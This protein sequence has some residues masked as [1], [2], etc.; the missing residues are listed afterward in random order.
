MRRY[1]TL[2][3]G[4]RVTLAAY[5]AAWRTCTAAAPGTVFSRG[6]CGYGS[7]TREQVLG[8]FR[9][10]VHDR[11]NR[12]DSRY[13]RGRKWD[14]D[15]WWS[16]MRCARAVNTPRLVVHSVPLDFAARLRHR[17]WAGEEW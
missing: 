3:D 1:V 6:L 5:A 15:W 9:D 10:G 17:V 4:T 8:E 2:G 11:I 12:H 13:G 7:R 16:A 14:A